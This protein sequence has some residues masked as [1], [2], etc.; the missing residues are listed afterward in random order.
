ML[1]ALRNLTKIFRTNHPFVTK[2]IEYLILIYKAI[3][4]FSFFTSFKTD[5]KNFIS[6]AHAR[7]VSLETKVN[8]LM[9]FASTVPAK[10]EAAP[11]AI[12]AAV[13]AVPAKVEAVVTAVPAE[14]AAVVAAVP[15]EV[16]AVVEAAK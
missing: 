12:A 2:T 9:H 5:V 4:M 11:A 14:A 16:A 15:G 13:E 8:A 7:I 3:D 10:V 1:E 6:D